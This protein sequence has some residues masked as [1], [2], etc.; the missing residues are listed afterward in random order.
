L[1]ASRG[2]GLQD[3]RRSDGPEEQPWRTSGNNAAPCGACAGLSLKRLSQTGKLHAAQVL[4]LSL[5][6]SQGAEKQPAPLQQGAMPPADDAAASAS[7]GSPRTPSPAIAALNPNRRARSRSGPLR[8]RTTGELRARCWCMTSRG[9]RTAATGR[10]WQPAPLESG[11]V[12][13][14]AVCGAAVH[15]RS[16]AATQP[17]SRARVG[18]GR[19][20]VCN[21]APAPREW[22]LVENVRKAVAGAAAVGVRART[23]IVRQRH[24]FG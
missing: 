4:C 19:V 18:D 6:A 17:R 9:E 2:R 20:A 24:R 12:A 22:R 11:S 23:R 1:L 21:R 10:L 16:S 14:C 15:W 8:G 7:R 5:L 3:T 13:S